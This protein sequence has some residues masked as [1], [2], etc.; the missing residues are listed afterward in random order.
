MVT[1]LDEL[2][3]LAY[4]DDG[5]RRL[6]STELEYG[7]GGALLLELAL[8][9]RVDVDG[10]RVVVVDASPVG[11]PLIDAA[12]ARVAAE[13]KPRKPGHWVDKLRRGARDAVLERLVA[14]GTLD[15][16]EQ[17]VLWVFPRTQY[18]V[19]GGVEPPAE[20]DARQRMRAAVTSTGDVAD[21]RTAALCSLVAAVGFDRKVFAD[22][23][24][25]DVKRRLKEIG[26]GAWAA[27]AV[28]RAIEEVYA[29]VTIAV[30]ASSTAAAAGGGS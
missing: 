2:V 15:R 13:Q 24:R 30:V 11:E 20:T 27:T 3:L 6:G 18:P 1:L 21:P 16:A 25:G 26:R 23:P 29:A 7:L 8:A 14:Q 4:D 19:P 17:K 12:L 28:K 9:G 5:E 22:L 10:N